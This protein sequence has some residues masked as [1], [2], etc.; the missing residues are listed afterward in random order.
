MSQANFPY[1]S[2][3]DQI[4]HAEWSIPKLA[5]LDQL[6][7]S[8]VILWPNGHPTRMVHVVGTSGKGSTCRFLE[9][10][11]GCMGKAGA[12]MS[13]HLFDYRERFSIGG[14]FASQKD[15]HWAWEERI[16]PI[17]LYQA[18]QPEGCVHTFHEVS[19]LIAL[20]LF[21]RH[22]VEWAAI[23]AG[24]GGRYDQTRALDTAATVLTNIGADHANLLGDEQ[25]QRALDKA[26]AA[27]RQTPFFTTDVNPENLAILRTVCAESQSPFY[28]LDSEAVAH[29][30]ATL[31]GEDIAIAEDSLLHASYQ[32][33]N[34]ALAHAV[35]RHFYPEADSATLLNAYARGRLLGR[36]WQVDEITYADV[37]HNVEK[38][39]ALAGEIRARF[40]DRNKVL[41]LGISGKRVPAQVFASLANSARA[42]IFTGASY[43]GQDPSQV[44]R[45][46]A[47]L[48]AGIPTLVIADPVRALEMARTIRRN[49]DLILLTGS[50]YMIEQ[51][52][53]PDPYLRQMSASFGWR[54]SVDS[55]ASGTLQIHLPKPPPPIR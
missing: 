17:C 13:P 3:I 12:F 37:A 29:F 34:A 2:T 40:G 23:E 1:Y 42:I 15:V 54:M 14:E 28:W 32:K 10:G 35:V 16:K 11:F 31:Q 8:I 41:V 6:R 38:I 33:C 5:R 7:K 19:I 39:G 55:E 26:G 27:R 53:N 4:Y 49:D 44:Q 18:N 20:A 50:T 30:A 46:L 24:I 21:E 25:W 45:E 52:L 36:F 43:K 51:A 9:I 22:E 47:E 48:T